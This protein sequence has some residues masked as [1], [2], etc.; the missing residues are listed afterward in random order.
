MKGARQ[1]RHLSLERLQVGGLEGNF[2]TGNP[3]RYARKVSGC[4]RLPPLGPLAKWN[5]VCG[6]LVSQ[7]FAG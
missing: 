3:G 2:F 7:D 5:L 1:M 6:G 4:R